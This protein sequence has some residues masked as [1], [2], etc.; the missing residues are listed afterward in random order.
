MPPSSDPERFL[1][2]RSRF[3]PNH[4]FNI[5]AFLSQIVDRIL[6]ILFDRFQLIPTYW[7]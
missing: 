6:E 1:G 3:H 7:Q 5:N 4:P 2:T